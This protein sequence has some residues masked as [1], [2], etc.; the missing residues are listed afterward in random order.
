MTHVNINKVAQNDAVPGSDCVAARLPVATVPA[1]SSSHFDVFRPHSAPNT[2]LGEIHVP[3]HAHAHT[4]T[5]A[6]TLTPTHSTS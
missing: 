3:T 5:R 4:Y 2:G 6:H 1:R